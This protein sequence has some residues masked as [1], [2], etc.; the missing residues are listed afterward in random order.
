MDGR[1]LARATVINQNK[2]TNR[3]RMKILIDG[4]TLNTPEINRGIGKYLV[5]TVEHILQTDFA[6]DFYVIAPLGSNLDVF[7]AWAREKLQV[8]EFDHTNGSPNDDASAAGYS[9]AISDL[10]AKLGIDLY[11]SPNGLMGNVF[12]PARGGNGSRYSATI[13]DL[14]PLVMESHFKKTWSRDAFTRYRQ[15]LALLESDYDLFIHISRHTKADFIERLRVTDKQ[16]VV[17]PLAASDSFRPYPFPRIADSEDYVLYPGGFDPRKNMDGALNAFAEMHHRYHDDEVVRKMRLR[18][19]CHI[20]AATAN[21]TRQRAQRLGIAD[22]LD[23]TGFVSDAELV[24]L[25]Q[26][27]RCL[28][29]PSL[30]EGF[31]LPVLEGL[32]CGLPIAASNTSSIPEVAGDLAS[33]FD[34]YDVGQMAEVLH[35]TVHQPTDLESRCSRYQYSQKFTWYKTAMAT[36]NAFTGVTNVPEAH[37]N[38]AETREAELIDVRQRIKEVN[39]SELRGTAEQFFARLDNWDYLHSKPFAAINETPELLIGFAH[40]VSGLGLLPDMTILDFGAGSC[41]TSRFLSQLGLK[42]IATDVSESALRIGK[43]LYERSPVIGN[44]PEASFL[45]FDG[46]RIDLPDASVDR[47]SCWDAFHHVPNQ[48]QVLSEMARVL[49]QGGI[50]GFSEPGPEHSRSPQ[51]QYEMRTNRVIENDI[52]IRDIWCIAEHCGFTKMKVAVFDPVPFL[53]SVEEFEDYLDTTDD[54]HGYVNA[55]RAQM[56][57]RRLFFLYKGE[58]DTPSDSRRRE[59]L[60]CDLQVESSSDQAVA[61][62]RLRLK[63]TASNTGANVWLPSTARVGAV[64]FGAHLFDKDSKLLDLDY[65]RHDLTPGESREVPPGETVAFDVDVP[66]PEQPGEYVLQFDLVS[67]QV[68]WFEHN[69]AGTVKLKVTCQ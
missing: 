49:K 43:A 25:Y 4:Q 29:F 59:G 47:I 68:C 61:G 44:Q 32:A 23:L 50:A 46:E 17:T 36:L 20:D 22:K 24:E 15:K 62:G 19:V 37:G 67:E 1:S 40:V 65:F 64:R 41:W 14:I 53:L 27:A 31:G 69:G 21:D 39:L 48:A 58:S 9:D 5:N 11:W 45:H 10:V 54:K 8:V 6:N 3:F 26:K 42:V 2:A 38:A 30:Y 51:S 12:L 63:C 28:F 16:H 18:L 60:L 66:L 56:R 57:F 33:Y 13:F 7:S 52:V 35:H 34:P 55:T